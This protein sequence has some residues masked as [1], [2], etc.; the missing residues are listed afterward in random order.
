[1]D[2]FDLEKGDLSY[3]GFLN[4]AIVTAYSDDVETSGAVFVLTDKKS[5]AH[6]IIEGLEKPVN[7]CFDEENEFLYVLDA[8]SGDQGVIYQYE[9]DWEAGGE[10]SRCL[11]YK[12]DKWGNTTRTCGRWKRWH[13]GDKF[14]LRSQSYAIVYEGSAPTDC[15]CDSYGNLYFATVD[16][17][18]Y[19]VSVVDLWARELNAVQ[20]LLDETEVGGCTG[21]DIRKNGELWW[22]NS[23]R[24]ETLGTLVR[25]KWDGEDYLNN[26]VV[27]VQHTAGPA[28]GLA[29]KKNYAYFITDD[30]L[31]EYQISTGEVTK[32]FLKSGMEPTS[33][34]YG[35]RQVWIADNGKGKVSRTYDDF[36]DYTE[37]S[38]FVSV[39]GAR[40]VHL[41]NSDVERIGSSFAFGAYIAVT[42]ALLFL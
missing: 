30:T 24:T 5:E 27:E 36:D 35:G 2:H 17:H 32:K 40:G 22:S 42:L 6:H 12:K 4:F 8:T 26:K 33:I 28:T 7:L 41:I 13:A 21:V 11:E 29:L 20:E 31:D 15:A 37:L 14:E 23:E 10:Y 38:V 39:P 3:E 25:M 19:G 9:I 34:G 18:I 1:M 16:N